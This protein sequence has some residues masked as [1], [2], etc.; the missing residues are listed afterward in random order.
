MLMMK[1]IAKGKDIL[2]SHQFSPHQSWKLAL[3]HLQSREVELI[4]KYISE[5]I[6]HREVM[7]LAHRYVMEPT[8]SLSP[9]TFQE[10]WFFVVMWF[11]L[12]HLVR[13]HSDHSL[14]KLFSGECL[15]FRKKNLL[16]LAVWFQFRYEQRVESR[17]KLEVM[18][19]ESQD[20]KTFYKAIDS[21][22]LCLFS[23]LVSSISLCS[24]YIVTY[25]GVPI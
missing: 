25:A 18:I 21:E 22:P 19:R 12:N 13:H 1:R 10:S 20:F 4:L 5:G 11:V 9:A 24:A 6:L 8:L 23:S 17:L 15:F 14:I 2:K 7:E 3:M 16:A